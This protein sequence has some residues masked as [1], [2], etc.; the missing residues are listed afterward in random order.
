MKKYIIISLLVIATIAVK[1][2]E[3]TS[4][5]VSYLPSI[6]LG[7]TADFSNNISPRG[8]DFEV[9][10]FLNE[11][12][13]VGFNI[14]W[15][16]FRE[17]IPEETFYYQELTITAVQFRYTNIVPLQV[18]V[19]KYFMGEG[20]YIPYFGFGLGTSYNETRNDVG[21]FSLNEDKWLFNIAPEIGM[22][23]DM[24]YKAWLSVKLKYN[25]GFKSGDFPA[26]SYLSLGV[27]IGLK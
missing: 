9:Q 13:S 23:Y 6:P 11:E 19:K 16:L 12:L 10:R 17:K 3:G 22:L 21:V 20:D 5:F 1:A 7:K 24:N 4:T 15:N 26:Q 2:Q 18:N 8:I 27:G 25:Y 14:G